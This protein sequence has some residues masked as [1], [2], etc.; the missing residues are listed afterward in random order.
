[1][2]PQ[3]LRHA[4]SANVTPGA[5]RQ[6]AIASLP[7]YLI[8][9][10][11]IARAAPAAG[12]AH[13]NAALDEMLDVAERRVL[14]AFAS[15]AH[16]DVVS[17]PSKPS[18]RRLS[19]WRC[20]SLSGTPRS[21]SQKRAFASTAPSAVCAPSIARPRQPRNHSIQGVISRSPFCVC[22]EDVVVV[23]ALLPD[24]RRHAVEALRASS[25]RA[26]AMSAIARAMRPLPSSNGWMV[27][28]HRCASAALRPDRCRCRR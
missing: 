1:M 3:R 5:M 4:C 25:E 27:T 23:A 13:Q 18:S 24:L 19:I 7:P 20:R 17:L 11:R 8:A 28:N 10:E 2:S 26:S 14:R 15:F 6:G 21:C 16:F 9:P 22:F 12:V